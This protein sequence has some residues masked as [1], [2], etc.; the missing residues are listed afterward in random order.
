MLQKHQLHVVKYLAHVAH[1][2]LILY[3][4]TC[5]VASCMLHFTCFMLLVAGCML[6]VDNIVYSNE[7]TKQ[8]F[9][10]SSKTHSEMIAWLRKT[11]SNL[12]YSERPSLDTAEYLAAMAKAV[13]VTPDETKT[14]LSNEVSRCI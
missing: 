14:F 9:H 4:S 12:G 6:H 11:Y 13:D 2:K 3:V 8:K 7:S 5:L 1:C 10:Q